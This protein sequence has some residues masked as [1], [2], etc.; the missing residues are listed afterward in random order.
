MKP[1]LISIF[2]LNIFSG[3]LS[4]NLVPNPSFENPIKNFDL[5]IQD[6][7]QCL[8][9]D[10]PDYFSF[11]KKTP[12]NNV[13]KKFI[14]NVKPHSGE[15]FVGVFLYRKKPYHPKA[16]VRE[17]LQTKLISSLIKDSIYTFEFYVMPDIE[18]NIALSN[19]A[20]YFSE[21]PVFFNAEKDMF[22]IKP[23]FEYSDS[24]ITNKF[25]WSKISGNYTASGGEKYMVLGIFKPD[26]FISKQRMLTEFA[27]EKRIPKWNTETGE[28]VSY[29]YFDDIG[30]VKAAKIVEPK[31]LPEIAKVNPDSGF[32]I[33]SLKVDSI[34]VLKNILF[35]LNKAELQNESFPEINK[36][37]KLLK[38]NPHLVID[39][40]GHT[41][42][43][44]NEK[45]NNKL[46]EDRANAVYSYL[47]NNGIDSTRLSYKG[48]GSKKLISSPNYENGEINRRVEFKVK[49]K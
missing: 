14:G 26:K 29:Y 10:S 12:S 4:Q 33:K 37:L 3:L 43:T 46:S 44:G 47:V 23:S 38:S 6:W 17:F 30:L 7:M 49:S 42:S 20:V 34:V 32:E 36:L 27:G 11:N 9:S 45:H 40:Y 1:I 15:A 19:F 24:C 31:I 13:F 16:N 22:K 39:I 48:F 25:Y 35:A 8:K 2:I 18:S 21:E 5:G 28:N 41:D